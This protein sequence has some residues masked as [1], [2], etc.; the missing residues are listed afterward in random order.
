MLARSENA[1]LFMTLLAGWQTALYRYTGE[2]DVCVGT[3]VAGRTQPELE[4]LIGF[5]V[6]TLVMRG[7]L[8][9]DPTFRELLGR[10]RETALA[11]YD[12]QDVPFE[13][14]VEDLAPRRDLSHSPLFQVSLLLHNSPLGLPNGTFNVRE[15][16]NGTAKYELTLALWKESDRLVGALEYNTALFDA[17][18]VQRL[19]GC[20]KTLLVAAMQTPDEH[21]SCLPLV[22]DSDRQ[23]MLLEWNQTDAPYRDNAC[24]HELFEEQV[25]RTPEALALEFDGVRLTYRELNARANQLARHLRSLQVGPDV[26]VGICVQRSPEMIIGVLGILKAGGAYLPLDPAYPP[27]RLAY[28]LEDSAARVLVTQAALADRL[29]THEA[30]L[31]LLDKETVTLDQLPTSNLPGTA[32][33]DNLAYVIYTSGSTGTPKGVLIEHRGVC[34]MVAAHH[35]PCVAVCFTEFRRFGG[36]NFSNACVRR[37]DLLGAAGLARARQ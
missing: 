21:V 7:D 17:A 29:G 32:R 12:H 31:V 10:T 19:L 25:R 35:E 28:M 33:A 6:N 22:S 20:F 4:P 24:I 15:V 16:H 23:R 2:T 34:H 8:R 14:L 18:T 3:A 36:G 11:A 27:A 30:Q 5:F 9:G 37:H 26:L 1:T 13:R